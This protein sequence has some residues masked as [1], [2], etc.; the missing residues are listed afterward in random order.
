MAVKTTTGKNA[1]VSGQYIPQGSKHEVTLVQGH[2]V[3]P[4][5]RITTFTLVDETKHKGK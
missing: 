1:P 2:R 5:G 4:Y 3:P